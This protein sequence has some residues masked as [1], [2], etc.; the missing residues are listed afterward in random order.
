MDN[1]GKKEKKFNLHEKKD[2]AIKSLFEVNCFLNKLSTAKNITKITN[3]IKP[4]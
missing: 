1:R 2:C 4:H 3:F